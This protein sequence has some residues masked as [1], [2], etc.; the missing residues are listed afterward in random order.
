M[1]D[2]IIP[3]MKPLLPAAVKILPYLEKM[4]SNRFYSNSGPLV[5]EFEERLSNIFEVPIV[6]TSSATSGLTACLMAL[7]LPH[8][9]VIAVPSWTFCA[10]VNAIISAGYVPCFFDTEYSYDQKHDAILAVAVFGEAFDWGHWEKLSVKLGIPV[11][12]DAASGFDSYAFNN[13]IGKIP[14]IF[15]THCTKVFGTGEGGFVACLD[16]GFLKNV[17]SICNNGFTHNRS[18]DTPGINGKMSEYHAAVGLAELDGWPDKRDSW[19]RVQEMYGDDKSWVNSTQIF[20]VKNAN[21]TV[22]KLKVCGIQAR[23]SWYGVHNCKAYKNYPRT[24]LSHTIKALE[25]TIFL[26]KYIGMKK[27]EVNYVMEKLEECV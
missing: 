5:K 1:G 16:E 12:V 6:T 20:K 14:V 27:E 10:S 8:G 24:N 13:L 18:I 15:S 11:V 19:F 23:S 4:D 7:G 9:S 17:R 21:E 22:D 25:E 3:I 26:P 2:V